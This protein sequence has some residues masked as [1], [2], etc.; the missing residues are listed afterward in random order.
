MNGNIYIQP[1]IQLNTFHDFL[2]KKHGYDPYIKSLEELLEK[3]RVLVVGEPGFGKSR[4]LKEIIKTAPPSYECGFFDLKESEGDVIG[5]IEKC[6]ADKN[7][8]N[9]IFNGDL[10]FYHSPKFTLKNTSDLIICLDALDEVKHDL[11]YK[12]VK[13]IQKLADEYKS[14][15]LF[16]SCRTHYIERD[17]AKFQNIDFAVAIV[18]HF[19]FNNTLSFI[20]HSCPALS[21]V[22]KENLRSK[23]WENKLINSASR[24][25]IIFTPRYLEIFVEL[26]QTEGVDEVLNYDRHQLFEKFIIKKLQKDEKP[27][28]NMGEGFRSKISYVKQILERLALVMEIQRVNSITKDEFTTFMLDADLNLDYQ[29]ALEMF[30]DRT[31][32]KDNGD[33]LEF[34]NTEFQ[35]YLAAKAITRLSRSGQVIFD[36]GVEQKLNDIYPNW[37]DVISFLVEIKPELLLPIIKYAERT[38]KSNHFPLIS[39]PNIEYFDKNIKEKAEIFNRI[40]DFFVGKAKF[41]RPHNLETSLARFYIHNEHKKLLIDSVEGDYSFDK[42]LLRANAAILLRALFRQHKTLHNIFTDE[43][44]T[45]WKNK[46]KSYVALPFMEG[47]WSV[48]HRYSVYA[49]TEICTSFDEFEDVTSFYGK[50]DTFSNAVVSFCKEVAPSHPQSISLFFKNSGRFAASDIGFNKI[51]TTEGFLNFFKILRNNYLLFKRNHVRKNYFDNVIESYEDLSSF[52]DSLNEC[53]NDEVEIYVCDLLIY[54]LNNRVTKSNFVKELTKTLKQ[55]NNNAIFILLNK[56]NNNETRPDLFYSEGLL[57]SIIQKD[58][59]SRVLEIIEQ[60][61]PQKNIGFWMLRNSND[62]E[63]QNLTGMY[64]PKITETYRENTKKYENKRN[65]DLDIREFVRNQEAYKRMKLCLNKEN[66]YHVIGDYARKPEIYEDKLTKLDKYKLKKLIERL[67]SYNPLDGQLIV[68]PTEQHQKATSRAISYPNWIGEYRFAIQLVQKLNIDITPYR[69]NILNYIPYHNI[70]TKQ[71]FELIP[72]PTSEEIENLIQVYK[73]NREDNLLDDVHPLIQICKR[74][75]VR[76]AT[77]ILKRIVKDEK[78]P[79]YMVLDSLDILMSWHKDKKY[80][81]E[82]FA[83]YLVKKHYQVQVGVNKFLLKLQDESALAWLSDEIKKYK[84]TN[85]NRHSSGRFT[86][87]PATS[88]PAKELAGNL[89]EVRD[90]KFKSKLLKLLIWS[91]ELVNEDGK[92]YDYVRDSIWKPIEQYFINFTSEPDRFKENLRDIENTFKEV[93]DAKGYKWFENVLDNI[94]NKYL[95]ELSEPSKIFDAIKKY[96]QLKAKKYLDIS[97]SRELYVLVKEVIENDLKFWIVNEGANKTIVSIPSRKR[98]RSIQD[99][100]VPKI[101]NYLLKKGLRN[102]D[103]QQLDFRIYKE[104]Q[105]AGD[106][107]IDLLI[108]Y[109][110]IGSIL[111]ELKREQNGDLKPGKR[112]KYKDKIKAYM[113]SV[114]AEYCILLVFKDNPNFNKTKPFGVFID[115][116]SQ[117]YKD[118]LNIEVLG[119]NCT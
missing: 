63:I 51:S 108:T 84:Y 21:T 86:I 2:E 94:R 49:L 27:A 44:I 82:I 13:S 88:N 107:R 91:F 74:Y 75:E 37:H 90:I 85:K 30:Y 35:E 18:H 114:Y 7:K 9:N 64:F 100:I 70:D 29:L 33:S 52:H 3:D 65:Q 87:R 16:I 109:G 105:T 103:I 36:I 43:E 23:L 11:F 113:K 76:S 1:T 56:L 81:N 111:L 79:T 28:S 72:D 54:A 115:E 50:E 20:E 8:A 10:I 68:G 53:W 73:S 32:L 5:Y 48:M 45:D 60:K 117:V 93:S 57:S 4:L 14:V 116:N 34:E 97:T 22:Q 66:H 110:S 17:K 96:N 99:L 61:Y 69:Q 41:I 104:A 31:V 80:L 38:Q 71:I 118:D 98:E 102:T 77:D 19:S 83:Y 40:F 24:N 78:S 26:I 12:T 58:Q 46:L 47:N 106:D 67:F 112:D 25:S 42:Y 15:K 55:K 92:Y 89:Y 95:V 59:V 62:P 101:E 39:Y 119:I 6:I